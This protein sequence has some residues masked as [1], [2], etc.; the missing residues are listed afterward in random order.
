MTCETSNNIIEHFPE[1][2]KPI[3]GGNGNI[4]NV[5]DYHSSRYACYLIVPNEI[6]KKS[7]SFGQT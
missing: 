1:F 5:I 3:T 7:V 6:L 4:Q 2:R